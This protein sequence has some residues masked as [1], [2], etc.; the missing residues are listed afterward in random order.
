MQAVAQQIAATTGDRLLVTGT[1]GRV[2]L[3]SS[4]ELVG[5]NLTP[6]QAVRLGLVLPPGPP[7]LGGSSVDVMFVQ[8]TAG[9]LS[10]AGV[11]THPVPPMIAAPIFVN[12]EQ[13]F[14]AAVTRSLVFGVRA[15]GVAA[16]C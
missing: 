6:D 15:G 5:Q 10:D 14:V 3:D 8:R 16:V 13:G 7:A 9:A 2:I 4:G 12:R 11:W 1:Q